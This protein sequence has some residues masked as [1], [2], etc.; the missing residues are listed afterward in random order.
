MTGLVNNHSC[1]NC[2]KREVGCHAK[3]EAY[4]AAREAQLEEY[5]RRKHIALSGYNLNEQLKFARALQK[6]RNQWRK[7]R[8][9]A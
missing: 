1:M 6:K 5:E 9:K 7:N 3:C 8:R 2:E 4:L